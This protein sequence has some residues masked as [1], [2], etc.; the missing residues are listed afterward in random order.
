MKSSDKEMKTEP[1]SLFT[2]F[3]DQLAR[4]FFEVEKH[5]HLTADQ[6]VNQVIRATA[7]ITGRIT[8]KKSMGSRSKR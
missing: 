8:I 1:L 6:K 2:K 4:E 3:K 7:F 5:P